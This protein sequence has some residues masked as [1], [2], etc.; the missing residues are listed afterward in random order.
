MEILLQRVENN[1]EFDLTE[2]VVP[3]VNELTLNGSNTVFVSFSETVKSVDL[4]NDDTVLEGIKVKV[5]GTKLYLIT[6]LRME[7]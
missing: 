5:N 1:D 4:D 3:T 7:S 6:L 2:N